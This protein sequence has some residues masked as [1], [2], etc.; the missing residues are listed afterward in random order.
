MFGLFHSRII[1]RHH[2]TVLIQAK[3][4]CL[5]SIIPQLLNDKNKLRTL[6][7]VNSIYKNIS[8]QN[9]DAMSSSP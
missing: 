4:V 1:D 7:R 8:F 3:S 5:A 2:I 9:V 6:S